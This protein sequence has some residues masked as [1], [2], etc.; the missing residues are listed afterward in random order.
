MTLNLDD[1]LIAK[2]SELTGVEEPAALV[3]MGLQALIER[4][5]AERL[6]QLAGTEK[7]LRLLHRRRM[8]R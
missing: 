8:R 5:N 4:K 1:E 2:A 6:A 3:R 7:P